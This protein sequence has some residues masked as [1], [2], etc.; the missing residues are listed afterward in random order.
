MISVTGLKEIDKVLRG[1]PDQLQDRVLKNAHT[2]A[3]KPLISAAKSIVHVKTG[4]LQK[5]IGVVRTSLKKTGAVGLV[6]VGP[7]RGGGNKG[8]HG[9][10]IEYGKTNRDGTRSRKFPFMEPAFNQTQSQVESNIATSLGKRINQF[11]KR[12]IKNG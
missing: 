6:Q 9:H 4:N 1:L 10:L 3:A 2:D 11:M 7:R 5:S 8:F 12:T